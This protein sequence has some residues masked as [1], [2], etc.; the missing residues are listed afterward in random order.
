[1][2]QPATAAQIAARWVD[3]AD[4]SNANEALTQLLLAEDRGDEAL[5]KWAKRY[6]Q[7]LAEAATK[8]AAREEGDNETVEALTGALERCEELADGALPEITDAEDDA[9]AIK[10]GFDALTEISSVAEKALKE[11]E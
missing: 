1:M 4:A 6:G 8:Y 7:A 9:A 10:A 11:A 2:A 3:M 5:L